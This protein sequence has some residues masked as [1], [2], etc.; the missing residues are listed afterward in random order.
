MS[1]TAADRAR[2]REILGPGAPDWMVNSCESLEDARRVARGHDGGGLDAARRDAT[3]R[4]PRGPAMI[5]RD[6]PRESAMPGCRTVC[7]ANVE[8]ERVEWLWDGRIPR[9]MLALVDGD[10]GLGKSTLTLDLVARVTTGAPMPCATDA[11]RRPPANVLVMSAE[12]HL[13]ATIRVRLDAAGAD[14]ARVHAVVAMPRIGEPDAPPALTPEGIAGLESAIRFH[15]A[16]LVVIDPLMA[17]L[18]AGVDAY[19][20][21][22]VRRVLHLLAACAERTGAAILIVRHLR[23]G[24]G[25]AL[26]RGGGSIGIAGAA[27]SVM[28][29]ATDPADES[30]RVIAIVKSNLAPS[31]PALRWRLVDTG[32]V[33]RVEWL[34]PAEGLTADEL[35]A[36][37]EGRTRD[38]AADPIDHAIDG[39]RQ[40]LADGP[41]PALEAERE[42]RDYASC[43]RAT[44]RRAREQIGVL[45]ERQRTAS[46]RTAGWVW[47]LPDAHA[48]AS[49]HLVITPPGN[50]ALSQANSVEPPGAHPLGAHDHVN[51]W[52]DGDQEGTL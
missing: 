49:E 45:C 22:D 35:A 48:H 17:Y 52:P 6:E 26:Y 28:L 40:V 10:P 24:A 1:L 21:Q 2:V 9:G 19:R 20:D 30:A 3:P 27:R 44:V 11:A 7:L 46:G 4:A 16:A 31:V 33:A 36:V 34:G 37:P 13:S 25:P 42:V 5:G 32:G 43:S 50:A 39:L 8:P 41:V 18:G 38:T 15:R 12:D 47:H 23:K 29:V 51:A 14:M